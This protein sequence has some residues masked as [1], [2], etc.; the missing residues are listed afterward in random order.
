MPP[1]MAA[2]SV[3]TTMNDV[4]RA[5]GRPRRSSS[6]MRPL[7]PTPNRARANSAKYSSASSRPWSVPAVDSEPW[8]AVNPVTALM[9]AAKLGGAAHGVPV[10]R[11]W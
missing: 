2:N 9:T 4:A 3:P 7:R 6:M 11:D 10:Y 1:P 8:L 5:R